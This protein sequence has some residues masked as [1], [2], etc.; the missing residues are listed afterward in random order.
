[1]MC[2]SETC[3]KSTYIHPNMWDLISFMKISSKYIG[4]VASMQEIQIDFE[5]YISL[6]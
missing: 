5:A 3:D 6:Q 1:M 2:T 4:L